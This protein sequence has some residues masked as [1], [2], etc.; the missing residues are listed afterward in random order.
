MQAVSNR[1]GP[2]IVPDELVDPQAD[3][4]RAKSGADIS[5]AQL[6][7]AMVDALSGA[8]VDLT[9]GTSE[10]ELKQTILAHLAGNR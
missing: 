3:N 5:R 1:T 9:S 2:N 10:Q 6:L 7:R 4:I 8:A